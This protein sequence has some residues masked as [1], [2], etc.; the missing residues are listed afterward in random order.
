MAGIS[1]KAA[2]KLEN[3]FKFN[4]GSELQHQEFSDGSGLEL[5]DTHFR[6]LDPQIGRWWQIDPKPNTVESPY[7]SMGNN[8]IL[9]NDP[10]GDTIR[11]LDNKPVSYTQDKKG[12][13]TWKNATNDIKKIGNLLLKSSD[14]KSILNKMVNAKYDITMKIDTKTDDFK[15][16]G[17]TLGK[18]STTLSTNG[19]II[20]ADITIFEKSIQSYMNYGTKNGGQ[21]DLGVGTYGTKLLTMDDVIGS[22]ATHEGTHAIDPASNSALNKNSTYEDREAKP[23]ENQSQYLNLR[24]IANAISSMLTGF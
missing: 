17:A 20:K 3:K 7:A 14:S 11:G 15:D 16:G 22:V 2:G 13:I 12:V 21:I 1:S 10:L 23:R 24:I 5:Y 8:P 19:K 4:K 6:Q 9:N 18:T